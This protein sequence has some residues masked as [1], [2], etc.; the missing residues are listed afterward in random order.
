MPIDRGGLQYQINVEGNFA[1]QLL[2]FRNELVEARGEW[3]RFRQEI[4]NVGASVSIAKKEMRA[5][6]AETDKEGDETLQ[7]AEAADLYTQGLIQ[8]KAV[9]RSL[10]TENKRLLLLQEREILVASLRNKLGDKS[11]VQLRGETAAL[12]QVT[13]AMEKDVAAR[14]RQRIAAELGVSALFESKKQLTAEAIAA[15][16]AA[17][18]QRDLAIERVL[19]QQ[20]L[21]KRGRPLTE[22]QGP[23][24]P[25]SMAR[26]QAA[27]LELNRQIERLKQQDMLNVLKGQNKE[28]QELSARVKNAAQ[29]AKGLNQQNAELETRGNRIAFTFRRLFGILAAFTIARQTVSA[30]VGTIRTA[31][32]AASDLEQ[33][34]LGI[35]GLIAS[36]ST[37]RNAQGQILQGQAEFNAAQE[38]SVA[39]LNRLRKAAQQTAGSYQDVINAFQQAFAPG[40]AAGLTLQEIE[41]VTLLVSQAASAIGVQQGALAEELRAL[42]T[43]EGSLRSTRLFATELFTPDEIRL[44]KEQGRLMELIRKNL[45]GVRQ[46]GKA[47]MTSLAAETSNASD[48]LRFLLAESGT[49]FFE[50]IKELLRTFRQQVS[51]E[52]DGALITAPKALAAF[53][54][55][56]D[57]I[58]QGVGELAENLQG[59]DLRALTAFLGTLGSVIGIGLDI[60]GDVVQILLEGAA[61]I[62][63]ILSGILKF[64]VSVKDAVV[65]L[66]NVTGGW[67]QAVLRIVGGFAATVGIINAIVFAVGKIATLTG[68]AR[69]AVLLQAST[70]LRIRALIFD[71]VVGMKNLVG[72]SRLTSKQFFIM[73]VAIAAS[74]ALL[75]KI[76]ILEDV[77]GKIDSLLAPII[78]KADQLFDRLFNQDAAARGAQEAVT[79]V[80]QSIRR[81]TALADEALNDLDKKSREVAR[82]VRAELFTVGLSPEAA[83]FAEKIANALKD[84]DERSVDLQKQKDLLLKQQLSN[85]EK[86]QKMKDRALELLDREQQSRLALLNSDGLMLNMIEER[87]RAQQSINAV[88]GKNDKEFFISEGQK[89]EAIASLTEEYGGLEQAVKRVADLNARISGRGPNAAAQALLATQKELDKLNKDFIEASNL[90]LSQKDAILAA[91][92][93]I[94]KIRQ[95]EVNL[96]AQELAVL[97]ERRLIQLKDERRQKEL[98]ISQTQRR[99]EVEE[100]GDENRLQTLVFV[101]EIERGILALQ[102]QREQVGRDA[103]GLDRTIAE[104]KNNHITEAEKLLLI[105][106]AINE[107]REVG[108]LSTKQIAADIG[109]AVTRLKEVQKQQ[110]DD[111][112]AGFG[113]GARQFAQDAALFKQGQQFAQQAFS[114]IGQTVGQ[115]VA[116]GLNPNVNEDLDRAIGE[117]ALS[118]GAQL[119]EIAFNKLFAS[120]ITELFPSLF[121]T[122]DIGAQSVAAAQLAV[123]SQALSAG[124]ILLGTASSTLGVSSSV[125]G[126]AGSVWT[127]IA[128]A[129]GTIASTL[130]AAATIMAA[131]GVGFGLAQG[132]PAAGLGFAVGGRTPSRHGFNR[133][134]NLDPRDTIPAWLRAGEWIIR[135]E[136]TSYYGDLAMQAINS[137]RVPKDVL[138]GLAGASGRSSAKAIRSHRGF[139]Q[140]GAVSRPARTLAGSP[141]ESTIIVTAPNEQTMDQTLAAGRRVLHRYVRLDS[142]EMR[143]SLGV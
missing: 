123:A 19:A 58:A 64:A 98:S 18:A 109:L 127:A 74:L 105:E 79:T 13:K 92:E 24:L 140:G 59:L 107:E 60:S 41:E 29:A 119:V 75:E 100:S 55:L 52:V 133:P 73:L 11:L 112:F 136:A 114:S 84:A 102:I 44:A 23:P 1:A 3:A 48:A 131:S 4:G 32:E 111:F 69:L 108:S 28:Y 137:L 72:L 126:A 125:L 118:L 124:A 97:S 25:E 30:F 43:G 83:A 42:L 103:A 53:Q 14:E 85:E 21:D 45:E 70:W 31:V 47:A 68:V 15:E 143:T 66:D 49:K 138:Q 90:E 129:W 67:L 82:S 8:E 135:P 35:S 80:T 62:L 16:R 9:K 93:A 116:D 99:A 120:L 86:L 63:S 56:F 36:V 71:I 33:T 26:E 115:Q 122:V 94:L 51:Q 38:Q 27:E 39:I 10:N 130:L 50:G 91:E 141:S 5:L 6:A 12:R 17:K 113:R 40:Q 96:A 121:S 142:K 95:L 57:G 132:G 134:R 7:A 54:A 34:G 106:T 89:R 22:I 46:A 139:A 76:G 110:G 61:P 78:Q 104:L 77:L 37:I 65:Q 20:G 81:I 88:T 2:L 128:P 87:N 117:L 101:E